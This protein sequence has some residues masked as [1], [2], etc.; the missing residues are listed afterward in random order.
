MFVG[1]CACIGFAEMTRV[2]MQASGVVLGFAK[3]ESPNLSDNCQ[4]IDGHFF[5]RNV[6]SDNR[7]ENEKFDSILTEARDKTMYLPD[8]RKVDIRNRSKNESSIVV[9]ERHT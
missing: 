1:K 8:K 2:A 6:N 4:R 9:Q 7:S 5:A 3:R